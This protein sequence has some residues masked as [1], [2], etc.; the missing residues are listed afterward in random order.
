MTRLLGTDLEPSSRFDSLDLGNPAE[1]VESTMGDA[2]AL[3]D[4]YE[5]ASTAA[6]AELAALDFSIEGTA[7]VGAEIQD[8]VVPVSTAVAP[9]TPTYSTDVAE[10][11]SNY[12]TFLA[13]L[14]LSSLELAS[15]VI[16]DLAAVAP[17]FSAPSVPD[18]ALP[19]IPTDLPVTVDPVVPPAP[20][21]E[22]PDEPALAEV[23]LSEVPVIENI[24]FDAILPTLELTA[25]DAA[26]S[27]NTEEYTSNIA[28]DV[29][30]KLHTDITEGGTG[31]DADVEE[32]IFDRA[33]D[34]LEYELTKDYD[35][36]L[37]NFETWGFEL[38]DG[39]LAANLREVLGEG[40]RRRAE[41]NKDVL[42]KQAE[43]AQNNT[44][45]ALT[46]GLT[47]EAQNTDFFIKQVSFAFQAAKATWDA[48]L[49]LFRG[50][51]D[52]FNT[53]MNGYKI[54]GDV[55]ESRVRAG[56]SLI[57]RYRIQMEGAKL[58]GDLNAQEVDIYVARIGALRNIVELWTAEVDGAR[59]QAELN[60]ARI[61]GFIAVLSAK[62]TQIDAVT[63]KF[64]LYQ[65]QLDGE[66]TRAD[67]YASEV[68]AH[69]TLVASKKV[70]AD[71]NKTE[72]ESAI[73]TNDNRLK[74][75]SE[76]IGAYTA[77]SNNVLGAAG[78]GAAIFKHEVASF[79]GEI[80]K[81]NASVAAKAEVFK[82]QALQA[83]ANA[84]LA[85]RNIEANL[86]VA[87]TL[88]EAQAAA[89]T[90]VANISAQKVASALSILN[91]TASINASQSN[92]HG[93]SV[94]SAYGF[95]ESNSD[96]TSASADRNDNKSEVTQIA[97]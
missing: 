52:E 33:S 41:L 6:L 90:A 1:I 37:N 74:V 88:T 76:S 55:F 91:V 23:E 86:R 39:F 92:S 10:V 57:E 36:E 83:D 48:A 78:V 42:V 5:A 85:A 45:F 69:A 15:V 35:A 8:L 97:G 53:R 24:Y 56:T 51:V 62:K 17:A 59:L 65:S 38:P 21:I 58:R 70:E 84:N 73:L 12:Q 77:E 32:A 20:T 19:E 11:L 82:A 80:N 72:L 16:P 14:D 43:L 44:Q 27:W 63:A 79:A 26:F 28:D 93:S 9:T 34:R 60:K 96:S 13:T 54:Q 75:L 2:A 18:D 40:T 3:V 30:V 22:F 94:S 4:S 47:H 89:A 64:N 50:K 71:V 95:S 29:R 67:I 31:L 49:E 87:A 46:S 25:P 66:K 7:I 61:D 68:Q 81:N